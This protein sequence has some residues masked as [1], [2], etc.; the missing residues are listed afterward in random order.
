LPQGK[1]RGESGQLSPEM[2]GGLAEADFLK[3]AG[4]L[5]GRRGQGGSP[6]AHPSRQAAGL[7]LPR[8][9][10]RARAGRL[11]HQRLKAALAHGL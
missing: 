3:L 2:V 7:D 4:L 11:R 10:R 9:V 1:C 5:F 6:V 8:S